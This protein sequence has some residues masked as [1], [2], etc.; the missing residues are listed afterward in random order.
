MD[1]DLGMRFMPMKAWGSLM[2]LV[3][4]IFFYALLCFVVLYKEGTQNQ[5]VSCVVLSPV[6]VTHFSS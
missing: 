2:I 6:L 4:Y 3:N 5:C 1:M